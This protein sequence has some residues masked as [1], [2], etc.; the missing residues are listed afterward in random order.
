MT[1]FELANRY[2]ALKMIDLWAEPLLK[3]MM[4]L[5]DNSTYRF[6]LMCKTRG[7]IAHDRMLTGRIV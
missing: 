4:R 2:T 1:K 6:G 3:N 7:M 5:N